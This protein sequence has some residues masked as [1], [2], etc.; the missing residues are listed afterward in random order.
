MRLH[1]GPFFIIS[2]IGPQFNSYFWKSFKN[3]LGIQV[4]HRIAF[5]PQ[6]NGQAH[7]TIQN[8][9]Y[10]FR[11]CLIVSKVV[12]MITFLLLSSP[13]AIATIPPFRWFLMRLYMSVYVDLLLV[14]LK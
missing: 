8:L 10:I 6:T 4:D 5:H 12:G 7:R 2:Y 13:K 3:G 11:A 1:G 9:E 14:G